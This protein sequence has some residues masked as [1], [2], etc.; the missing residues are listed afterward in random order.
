VLPLKLVLPWYVAVIVCV[1]EVSVEVANF[2][3][4]PLRD[5]VFRAVVPS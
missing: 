2:A 3:T 4:P 5:A 1:P